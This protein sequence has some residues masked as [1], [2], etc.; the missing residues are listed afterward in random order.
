MRLLEGSGFRFS[1]IAAL[2]VRLFQ[3]AL[4]TIM[5][6]GSLA[7]ANDSSFPVHRILDEQTYPIFVDTDM[8]FIEDPERNFTS[9]QVMSSDNWQAITQA[10]PNFGFTQSA[11]WFRFDI[12]N[13]GRPGEPIY[14]EFPNPFL[15]LIEVRQFVSGQ[16]LSYQKA[17]DIYPYRHRP[18]NHQNFVFPI[19]LAA[20]TNQIL[21]RISSEGSIEGTINIWSPTS[22][23]EFSNDE[24]TSQGFWMGMMSIMIIYNFLLLLLMRDRNF[25][26][27][28]LLAS[29]FLVFQS[30]L[31]GY[32][33]A[34]IWPTAVELNTIAVTLSMAFCSLVVLTFTRH[35]LELSEYSPRTNKLLL[36][37]I[38]VAGL[39]L[40][41]TFF[42]PYSVSIFMNAIMNMVGASC[43][44]YAGIISWLKGNR[45]AKFYV[46]AWS[47]ALLGVMILC[48]QKFGWLPANY[49]TKNAATIG[50]CTLMALVSYG[51][52]S[53][54]N[55]EKEL[56]IS[57]QSAALRSEKVARESH[58]LIVRAKLDANRKLEQ[59][60]V[61]RTQHLERT[62]MQLESANEQLER[63]STT[64]TLTGISNR[65]VVEKALDSEL[66]R[67]QRHN[68]HFSVIILDV[69]FF[70]KVNDT[71]GHKAGDKC[72]K[73]VADTL[74]KMISRPGDIVARF[75]GEEFIVL[76]ADTPLKNAAT[77]AQK[78]CDSLRERQ[79]M[80]GS[81][82][83]PIT[84]SFGVAS[85]E[86]DRTATP[87]QLVTYADN[88]L[89]QA[90]ERGRDQVV[91]W[92]DF[93]EVKRV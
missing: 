67:A 47:F 16:E 37:L 42:I 58:E 15:D 78:L 26:Y 65:A 89:Y 45:H 13:K 52:A 56:R 61:E 93:S 28:T 83:I 10:A 55:K 92:R 51:L 46:F 64:D 9:E 57:A 62:L 63:L 72:L 44:I 2:L 21:V 17:G 73:E 82:R 79:I 20:S 54:F 84:A 77:L 36:G 81:T 90:K 75:G 39:M 88:A 35:Y 12:D 60:V 8:F 30:S 34:Y 76:L 80:F 19:E 87:D 32:A 50:V 85:L 66:K 40:V 43:S 22:F 53:R 1:L 23:F 18:L 25:L 71:H 70:K 3:I 4:I 31:N 6:G 7:W 68:H 86:S 29:G 59:K 49:W 5:M 69:D 41:A 27:Y 14:L 33:Y 38:A 91:C 24:H 48:A 74:Q 11:Y